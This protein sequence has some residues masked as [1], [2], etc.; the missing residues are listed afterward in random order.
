MAEAQAIFNSFLDDDET[1]ECQALDLDDI[2][3]F[4]GLEYAVNFEKNKEIPETRGL[5]GRDG[6]ETVA[7]VF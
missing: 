1:F 7:V 3:F 4:E 5:I 2:E 6:W